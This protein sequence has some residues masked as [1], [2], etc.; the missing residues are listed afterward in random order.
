M[1]KRIFILC[2]IIMS[3]LSGCHSNIILKMY[4]APGGAQNSGIVHNNILFLINNIFYI[5]DEQEIK[6]I[7]YCSVENCKH[8]YDPSG[9]NSC[10][11]AVEYGGYM[12]A[13]DGEAYIFHYDKPYVFCGERLDLADMSRRLVWKFSEA[14]ESIFVHRAYL[15]DG[16]CYFLSDPLSSGLMDRKIALYYSSMDG[17]ESDV[18]MLWESKQRRTATDKISLHQFQPYDSVLM[19]YLTEGSYEENTFQKT[20]YLYDTHKKE[21]IF[22][23]HIPPELSE[24]VTYIDG[25]LLFLNS[26]DR[27][28]DIYNTDKEAVER[29]INVKDYNSAMTLGCDES[30]IY[31]NNII[32]ADSRP[33]L[34]PDTCPLVY[35]YDFS[36][37]MTDIV[38]WGEIENAYNAFDSHQNSQELDPWE[39]SY[40]CSTQ[41]FMFIGASQINTS[42]QLFVICKDEIG[43]GKLVKRIY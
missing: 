40:V 13:D 14:Q 27:S 28:I 32:D 33:D 5:F 26:Q 39:C 34:I 18:K 30:Y 41:D 15:V 1:K 20:L 4:H 9:D 23:E 42:D 31:I 6:L 2:I 12:M 21:M 11:A 22:N 19:I 24:S 17:L 16:E 25:K 43:Q 35:I 10:M 29:K 7:P 37:K 8:I 36:G 38:T 3:I